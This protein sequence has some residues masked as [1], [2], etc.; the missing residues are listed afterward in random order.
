MTRESCPSSIPIFQMK[1][2]AFG[3]EFTWG[4]SLIHASYMVQAKVNERGLDWHEV[5]QASVRWHL[6]S[7]AHSVQCF[8]GDKGLERKYLS[9]VK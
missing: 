3:M 9:V 1:S 8:D 6:T 7:F 2:T 5:W 4:T